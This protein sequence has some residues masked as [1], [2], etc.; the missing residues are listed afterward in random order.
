MAVDHNRPLPVETAR[1]NA[2]SQ[3]L[4]PRRNYVALSKEHQ[5]AVLN[6]A[7]QEVQIEATQQVEFYLREAYDIYNARFR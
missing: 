2:I 1:L 6:I 7:L 5:I 4:W 3:M